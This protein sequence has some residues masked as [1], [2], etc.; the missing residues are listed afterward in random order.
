MRHLTR[1]TG[2]AIAPPWTPAGLAP[3][4]R[5]G[6]RVGELVAAAYGVQAVTLG[7]Q[8]FAPE[9]TP[10]RVIRHELA[11]A[12]QSR[13]RGPIAGIASLE[14]EAD[15]IAEGSAAHVRLRAPLGIPL[16]HPAIKPLI[17]SG[18]WLAR[19]TTA[20]L[21]KHVAK[22]GRRIADKAVHSIFKDTT[23]IA[24]LTKSAVDDGVALARKYAEKGATDVLDEA[25]VTVT[26]QPGRTAGKFRTVIQKDFKRVIGTK[27]ETAIRVVVDQSGRIVT[28]FPVN[29]AT[30]A[31]GV[32]GL[33]LFT[34]RTA[35]AAEQVRGA[36]E[37]HENRPPNWGEILGELAIDIA[38]VGLLAPSTL[39]ESEDLN[40]RIDRIIWE[41]AQATIL[42]I[43]QAEGIVLTEDQ[44]WAIYDL[45]QVAIGSP[46]VFEDIE[47]EVAALPSQ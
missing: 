24:K 45:A 2:V 16:Y 38:S 23:E 25:G 22:H 12:A 30:L 34:E 6:G 41:A 21:S 17:R 31:L 46:M 40:V 3:A 18:T 27:G 15:R 42:E 37:E 14:S 35:E 20:T 10:P 13:V 47:D 43:E 39:D 44:R 19:R 5:H 7:Q 11:H 8:I 26:I 9:D 1:R 32:V 29:I 28:A 4:W 36:I 33:E